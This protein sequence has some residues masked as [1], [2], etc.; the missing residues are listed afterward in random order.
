MNMNPK[1]DGEAVART[2]GVVFKE[3]M[4]YMRNVATGVVFPFQVEAMKGSDMVPFYPF[5]TAK[6]P[7]TPN[8]RKM[9]EAE[10][11]AWARNQKTADTPTAPIETPAEAK[12]SNVPP[13]VIALA[14]AVDI[15]GSGDADNTPSEL[16]VPNFAT[17]SKVF[18]VEWAKDNLQLEVD[19]TSTKVAM[20]VDVRAELAKSGL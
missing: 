9:S 6:A 19:V 20:L 18:I 16:S 14:N 1:Y 10:I 4:S 8:F 2:A 5:A 13:E 7:K 11:V 15:E 17:K 3:N 12:P